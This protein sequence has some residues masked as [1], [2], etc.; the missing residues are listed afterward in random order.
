MIAQFK[1]DLY[2]ENFSLQ[3]KGKGDEN[4]TFQKR[5]KFCLKVIDMGDQ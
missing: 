3:D 5:N 4:D 1:Q 2:N